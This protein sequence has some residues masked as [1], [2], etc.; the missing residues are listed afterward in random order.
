V[1]IYLLQSEAVR[2]K[3]LVSMRENVLVEL[4][5]S[6]LRTQQVFKV[7]SCL[8]RSTAVELGLVFVVELTIPAEKVTS[9]LGADESLLICDRLS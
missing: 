9:K 3:F 1:S 6:A 2:E 5:L 7:L 8:Q 4:G